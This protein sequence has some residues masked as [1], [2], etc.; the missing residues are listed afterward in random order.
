MRRFAH[1][2]SDGAGCTPRARATSAPVWAAKLTLREIAGPDKGRETKLPRPAAARRI[3]KRYTNMAASDVTDRLDL[4][5]WRDKQ[6]MDHVRRTMPAARPAS[7]RHRARSSAGT[8]RS[9]T[10]SCWR[11]TTYP[12]TSRRRSKLSS[13]TPITTAA[14]IPTAESSDLRAEGPRPRT[15]P[16][17]RF[18][19]AKMQ[20]SCAW[21]ESL[22]N[23]TT[24]DVYAG[25]GQPILLD[26][27]RIK[28]QTIQFCL[29]G[30]DVG[31][32][33]H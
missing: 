3:W 13:S 19:G 8:R 32:F 17:R 24:A 6:A 28:R 5:Q 7:P 22:C 1:A 18:R 25:R 12:A 20:P 21:H 15:R 4:A 30:A 31:L 33:V 2:Y 9:R 23:P 16:A 10:A 26:H 11:T 14:T 27:E 29:K